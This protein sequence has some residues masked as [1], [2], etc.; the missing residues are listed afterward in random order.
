MSRQ[1]DSTLY[2]GDPRQ[3]F[4]YIRRTRQ[5]VP[6]SEQVFQDYY[7]GINAYRRRMQEYGRCICPANRRLICDMDCWTCPYHRIGNELPLG[8]D[9]ERVEGNMSNEL[10]QLSDPTQSLVEDIVQDRQLL[11]AL[12]ERLRTLDGDERCIIEMIREGRSARETAEGIG[13]H[14]SKLN[15]HKKKLLDR[16]FNELGDYI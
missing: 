10:D 9:F 11:A 6:V 16:L 7:R 2:P 3:R 5:T 1:I 12:H 13:W 15:R 4:I 8:A 14:R